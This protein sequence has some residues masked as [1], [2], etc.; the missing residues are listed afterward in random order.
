MKSLT[1]LSALLM[2][3][4]LSFAQ[5]PYGVRIPQPERIK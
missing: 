5:S 1:F 3:G 2:A 4:A